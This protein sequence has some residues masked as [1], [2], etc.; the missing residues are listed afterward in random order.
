MIVL[1]VP[2]GLV[3]GF[4]D[5]EVRIPASALEVQDV[6]FSLRGDAVWLVLHTVAGSLTLA[7]DEWDL[8]GCPVD[9][10]V[11]EDS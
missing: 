3:K 2:E 1:P 7:P 11:E 6:E 5:P 8:A 10:A 4:F 9:E